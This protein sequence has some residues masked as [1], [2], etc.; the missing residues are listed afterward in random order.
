[1]PVRNAARRVE[2]ERPYQFRQELDQVHKPNRRDSRA[3][4][5]PGEVAVENGWQI[6]VPREAGHHLVKA[7]KDL[8]DYLLDSMNVSVSIEKVGSLSTALDARRRVIVIGAKA[9]LPT[10]GKALTVPRSYRLVVSP[11]RIIV[12]GCDERGAGQGSFFLEDLMNLREAPFVA[13]QDQVRRP[14]FSPRMVHSGWGVDQFPD[15][16]LNA[17]AHAGMDAILLFTRGVDHTTQGYEDVND[18]VRRA[19]SFGIDVYFYSYLKSTKHPDEPDAKAYYEN[20]YGALFKACPG[21]KGVVLVGESVEFPSKDGR[22]TGRPWD[23]LPE[24]GIPSTKPSPGWWPCRDYPQWIRMLKNAV[25]KYKPDA[26]IVFWTYNWGWAPEKE[27]LRLIRNIPRDVT[28]LVTFEMFEQLRQEG[29]THVCVDYTI[30]SVGPGRYFKTEAAAARKRGLRL[31]TMCNTAGMTWDVGV[32]PYEPV[33]QQWSKRRAALVKA[34][35]RW[36]LSGLMES[37]HY[38]WWPSCISEG[39][40]WSYWSP[41]PSDEEVLAAILRRDYGAQAAPLVGKALRAWSEAIR[42]Y[43]PTNEDQ[44]GP[45]RIGPSYPLIFQPICS[46]T[47]TSKDRKLPA[48]WHAWFGNKVVLTPYQ[49]LDDSRQS[50]GACRVDLEIR[51]LQKMAALWQKGISMLGKA[52]R[53]MPAGR[54]KTGERLLGLGEFVL[55]S[56]CTTIHVK[57]WWKLNQRLMTESDARKQMA[58]LDLMVKLAEQEIRNAEETI[59]LVEKDSRL[60]WEPTMEYLTDTDHLRW[61]MA[62]VRSVVDGEI[63]EYRQTLLNTGS[64][65]RKNTGRA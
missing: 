65:V 37:H 15:T 13:K 1:M 6:L 19:D 45:F 7:A 36:G 38:G 24:N 18:L 2:K 49:P 39:A 30:S 41:S 60:G 43:V 44:Y 57:E 3:R 51:S 53:L 31:Y 29:I 32:I 61:K 56:I 21:A 12:C 63:P 40:K 8:Q 34:R 5:R 55:H 25:Q 4:V 59:P 20:T 50:P 54:R 46:R 23:S 27:R 35:E 10:I 64:A 16:Q 26:D 48:A 28:L 9:E 42:F 58:A 22:T 11:E 14:L 33:P 52:L 62:Q 47:F 17:I